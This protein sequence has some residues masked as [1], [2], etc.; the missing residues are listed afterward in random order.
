MAQPRCTA[1]TKAGQP[2]RMPAIAD[3]LCLN[4]HPAY[5]DRIKQ[6]RIRGG[7]GSSRANRAAKNLP[8]DLQWLI[9]RLEIVFDEVHRGDLKPAAGSTLASLAGAIC[10]VYEI[11]ELQ[12]KL[13]DIE[14]RLAEAESKAD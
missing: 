2:C 6:A 12:A 3:G 1:T 5:R 13:A 10:K 14:K 11:G 8:S 4:H 9:R 7:T